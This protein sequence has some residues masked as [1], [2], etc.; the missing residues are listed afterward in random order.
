MSVNWGT[1]VEC[2]YYVNTI[3]R[4]VVVIVE[5]GQHNVDARSLLV[6]TSTRRAL[7]SPCVSILCFVC[8]SSVGLHSPSHFE[9]EYMYYKIATRFQ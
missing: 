9:F 5:I 1:A 2:S 6:E 8:F 4:N 7:H 3:L